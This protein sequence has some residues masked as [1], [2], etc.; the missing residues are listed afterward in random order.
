MSVKG[1]YTK[2]ARSANGVAISGASI[3]I[4][5]LNGT[6]ATVEDASG[7]VLTQ[8]LTTD[9]NGV[10]NF[11]ASSGVYNITVVKSGQ[12]IVLP[13]QVV[14]PNEDTLNSKVNENGAFYFSSADMSQKVSED[15]ITNGEGDGGLYQAPPSDKTGTAG[16]WVRSGHVAV[17]PEYYGAV[18]DGINDDTDA[19]VNAINAAHR[20]KLPLFLGRKDYFVTRTLPVYS[21]TIWQGSG[22]PY[23]STETLS[24]L[25]VATSGSDM[26]IFFNDPN[27]IISHRLLDGD[28]LKT[29]GFADSGNN[30]LF[31]VQSVD[32]TAKSVTVNNSSAVAVAAAGSS[33]E[34]RLTLLTG[35]TIIR[36]TN[37]GNGSTHTGDRFVDATGIR[38]LKWADFGFVGPGINSVFGGGLRFRRTAD[39][40]AITGYHFNN[41][42]LEHVAMDGLRFDQLIHSYLG[43]LRISRCVGDGILFKG[44]PNIGGAT[45]SVHIDSPYIQNCRRGIASYIS[46][47]CSISNPV[48]EGASVGYFFDRAI[49]LTIDAMG[50]ETIKFD[51]SGQSNGTTAVFSDS[52]GL[53]LNSPTVYYNTEEDEWS[54]ASII[55]VDPKRRVESPLG[56]INGGH[57]H[58][59]VGPKISILGTRWDATTDTGRLYVDVSG[60]SGYVPPTD[61]DA[62]S[63]IGNSYW[64]D[65]IQIKIGGV[66]RDSIFNERYKVTSI[67]KASYFTGADFEATRDPGPTDDSNAGFNDFDPAGSGLWKNTTKVGDRGRFFCIDDTPGAARWVDANSL[68]EIE[69]VGRDY[70]PL[71]KLAEPVGSTAY[72]IR[73]GRNYGCDIATDNVQRV[74]TTKSGGTGEFI[75]QMDI[76]HCFPARYLVS[77]NYNPFTTASNLQYT[78][79]KH[80]LV[81]VSTVD[82]VMVSLVVNTSGYT[83]EDV[84]KNAVNADGDPV[85]LE[86]TELGLPYKLNAALIKEDAATENLFVYFTADEFFGVGDSI[87]VF[88]TR[89]SSMEGLWTVDS[90][91][92]VAS[93]ILNGLPAV[94]ITCTDR[95][96]SY[97]IAETVDDAVYVHLDKWSW[98]VSTQ[99][100]VNG[101]DSLFTY[102]SAQ[103]VNQPASRGGEVVFEAT[104]AQVTIDVPGANNFVYSSYIENS[105]TNTRVVSSTFNTVTFERDNTASKE[106]AVWSAKRKKTPG[107]E[108]IYDRN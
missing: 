50:S 88:N 30:G 53:V 83:F 62:S 8:P 76:T 36:M 33:A 71:G 70:N 23:Q 72:A 47:Y 3:T 61:T 6:P 79:K 27:N 99:L 68:F 48:I 89:L 19:L 12:T 57:I 41:I 63:W 13:Q 108:A 5:N 96:L 1:Y 93:S 38:N 59:S 97:N 17:T 44:A 60:D 9:A 100:T 43:H 26:I 86:F 104:V 11:Y 49:G 73:A 90:S 101:L 106:I 91:R 95:T 4:N 20:E 52:Y 98:P 105:F 18:G 7:T 15:E 102:D 54:K 40:R 39:N 69:F 34:G 87:D 67:E 28:P 65:S 46:A 55:F 78:V 25:S 77:L 80:E 2:T 35:G 107:F 94:E 24:V 81:T 74:L 31:A 14:G 103:A 29:S 66:Q 64:D 16:A 42:R 51:R 56:V 85:V 58:W 21:G 92:V 37:L 32:T 75:A 45:T 84:I 10:F 22:M 82:Y